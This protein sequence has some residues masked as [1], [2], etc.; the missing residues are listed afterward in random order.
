MGNNFIR[1]Q[2]IKSADVSAADWVADNIIEISRGRYP[3]F[4]A[5]VLKEKLVTARHVEPVINAPVSIVVNF[6][7]IGMWRGDAIDLCEA[8]GKAWGQWGE[9]LRA[10][11]N[12]TP[13]TT[14]NPKI[15]FSRRA[16]SQHSRVRSVHFALDHLLL[17]EHENGTTLRVALLYEYDLCGND[18]RNAVDRLGS[19]DLILKTNPNGSI[20][21]DACEVADELG[22]KVFGIRDTLA[23]L[24]RGKF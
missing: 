11:G 14:E 13:E 22:I 21:S 12:E 24:A 23:Y 2:L 8:H 18:V 16:L 9:L 3:P 1:D 4:Q 5:A 6:P 10:L 20:L 15:A 7:K 19:F 17:V